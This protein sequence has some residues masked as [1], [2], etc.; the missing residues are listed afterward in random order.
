MGV[1]RAGVGRTV[2]TTVSTSTLPPAGLRKYI[3]CPAPA[4]GVQRQQRYGCG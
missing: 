2:L 1:V 3:A 4:N